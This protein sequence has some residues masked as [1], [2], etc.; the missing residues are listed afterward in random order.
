MSHTRRS[1]SLGLRPNPPLPGGLNSH[2]SDMARE[3]TR[4]RG[5]PDMLPLHRE[6][7]S[8]HIV[9]RGASQNN[10]FSS[11]FTYILKPMPRVP[12]PDFNKAMQ[13]HTPRPCP[14]RPPRCTPRTP[15][16]ARRAPTT[17]AATGRRS[18][19]PQAPATPARPPQAAAHP[20][21]RHAHRERQHR[22]RPCHEPGGSRRP[23]TPA[24]PARPARDRH[25]RHRDGACVL[26][27]RRGVGRQNARGVATRR[28]QAPGVAN[29]SPCCRVVR[30][31]EAQQEHH[32]V[33]G[34]QRGHV[35][36]RERG[37]PRRVPPRAAHSQRLPPVLAVVHGDDRANDANAQRH[38]A[39][40]GDARGGRRRRR[41]GRG[42]RPVCE[43][44]RVMRPHHR[45]HQ[46]G[47][48]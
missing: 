16:R 24:V 17:R 32:A 43:R 10:H 26:H 33:E 40:A 14:P 18:R 8:R 44:Q 19:P 9:D 35:G 20:P 45:L 3:A 48:A 13:L 12:R 31:G 41:R 15:P 42:W 4:L 1:L 23:V 25:T 11:R 21:L 38:G 28:G 29:K 34:G 46:D 7:A 5:L 22:R 6:E 36:T 47:A 27:P 37:A 2:S 39:R 30:D